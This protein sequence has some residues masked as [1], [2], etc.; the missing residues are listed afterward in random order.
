MGGGVC[1]REDVDARE[2]MGLEFIC[3]GGDGFMRLGRNMFRT[4]KP[5][6]WFPKDGF[7]LAVAR[8]EP[9]EPFGPHTHG[10]SEVVII[11]SESGLHVAGKEAWPLTAGDIFVIGGPVPHDYQNLDHLCLVNI[12]FRPEKLNLK[13]MDLAMV[14]GYH[15][16]FTLEPAWR[17]RHQFKSRLHV[18]AQELAAVMGLVDQL[19]EELKGRKP[20][21]GFLAMALFMQ[22]VAYLSR[23]YG[24]S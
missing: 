5:E 7:P 8:R 21:F 3:Q 19:E 13:L 15:A 11:I 6:D 22:I 17:Q 23:C 20:G 2:Q 14:P 10:L 4:L 1:L 16:L 18:S 12:L 9:Q 24:R